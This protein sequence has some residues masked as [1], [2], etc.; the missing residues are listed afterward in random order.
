MKKILASILAAISVL[1]LAGC[2]ENPVSPKTSDTASNPV[3]TSDPAAITH[4]RKNF[5]P[6]EITGDNVLNS[7][8]VFDTM[9][10]DNKQA[11]FSPLSLNMCLGMVEAGADGDTKKAL[12][13]Y[14]G[15]TDYAAFAEDYLAH[16]KDF[17]VKVN[18]DYAKYQNVFE[19]ANSFWANKNLKFNSDYQ[20]RVS[21]SFAAEIENLDF[22]KSDKA[23]DKINGWVNKKTHEMIPSIVLPSMLSEDTAAVLVNTV[24]FESAWD[25]EWYVPEEKK[26]FTN[27][28]GSTTELELMFKGG[29]SYFENDNATA[30][31][32]RYKNGM[33]FIG[34]LPKK[35]GDFTLESLDLNSLLES[36]SFKY[37]VR[38]RMP[39]LNFES[40]FPL[41]EALKA[42]GLEVAFDPD[43]ADFT[44]MQGSDDELFYISDVLQKTK[45]ELDD[46]GTRAAAATAAIITN[47]AEAFD[48]TPPEIKEVFLDRPFAFLIY[49]D[50]AEQ[51]VFMGKVTAM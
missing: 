39:K 46:E 32:C 5:A 9:Y 40:S 29:N 42:A 17:N 25:D 49:D 35:D 33:Q 14:L 7:V 2:G 6:I 38:A 30:F 15:S 3:D 11:M 27:L 31:S 45:L 50:A 44:P 41:T 28:D 20:K 18:N 24:Y 26:K 8:R 43:T 10:E 34:I 37:D 22:S 4:E 21:T 16:S 1:S 13:A 47:A 23:A 51:I 48:P 19:I 12:D 36:E